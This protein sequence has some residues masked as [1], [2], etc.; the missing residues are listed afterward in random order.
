MASINIGNNDA[1]NFG[2][3]FYGYIESVDRMHTSLLADGEGEG[4]IDAV[5]YGLGDKKNGY[6][7][8]HTSK[9]AKITNPASIINGHATF[10]YRSLFSGDLVPS[11][12]GKDN[13]SVLYD[14]YRRYMELDNGWKQLLKDIENPTL[15]KIL[16][17]YKGGTTFD[18]YGMSS[19]KI[20]DFIY[21]KYLNQIPF[22]RLVTVRRYLRPC[23]DRMF[24]FDMTAEG[25]RAIHDYPPGFFA[26]ATAVTYADEKA[27]N[28]LSDILKFK[29]GANWEDKEAGVNTAQVDNKGLR[30][31]LEGHGTSITN[32]PGLWALAGAGKG[33]SGSQVFA[34]QFNYEG[35]ALV[36]KYGDGVVGPIDVVDKTKVR[37]RGL[38]Y[39]NNFNLRFSYELKELKYI[40]P[41]VAMLDV[42]SNFLLL[43]GNYGKFWGGTTRFLGGNRNIASPYGN[44]ELLRK[45]DLVGYAKSLVGDVRDGLHRIAGASSGII[46]TAKK[47]VESLMKNGMDIMF[48][49]MLQGL[50]GD[51]GNAVVTKALLS[52]APTGFWH[53]TI[54]NPL[55]P[56]AMMGNMGIQETEVEFGEEL[57]YDDFPVEV[58]F[59]VGLF[60]CQPR[61]IGSIQNMYNNARGRIYTLANPETLKMFKSAAKT[62]QWASFA[63][64]KKSLGRS[65]SAP[66]S[67]AGKLVPKASSASK[68]IIGSVHSLIKSTNS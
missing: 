64:G 66:S 11:V 26:F 40:N 25:H 65:G 21:L 45:G 68:E 20:Q 44:P 36:D 31:Q 61:D 12:D 35:D 3:D 10:N 33:V 48:G 13:E 63:G 54:G 52:G 56:I 19:Y 30:G 9:N 39:E 60:H 46:E 41:K 55:N 37:S 15:P 57:G 16:D 32:N 22:N 53:V 17:Y 27:G 34:S 14:D 7:Q 5:Q 51:V 24:G 18:E 47:V 23:D 28:K 4:A 1:Q 29:Y 43:T 38:I 58:N 59:N 67:L 2:G 42:I 50:A 62:S 49:N 6:A 8:Y